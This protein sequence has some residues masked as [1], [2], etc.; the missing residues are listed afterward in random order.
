M[1]PKSIGIIGGLGGM[2]RAM[3]RF[4]TEA[5]YPVEV[6]DTVDGPISWESIAENDV[7]L[8]AVPIPA[9]EGVVRDL[10]PFTRENGL[11]MDIASIKDAPVQSM[12]QHCR[13][14]VIGTHP[15]FGPSTASLEK[16]VVFLCPG[17]SKQWIDWLMVFLADQGTRVVEIEPDKHDRLMGTVQVLRHMLLLCLGR[18]LMSLDFDLANDLPSS[19]PWFSHLVEMLRHQMDQSPELYADIASHNPATPEVADHFLHA[20]EEI[21]ASYLS[22]NHSNMIRI[23]NEVSSYMSAA[24]SR[25]HGQPCN[26]ES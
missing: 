16:Q 3:G 24:S 22:K 6:A 23:M 15:L 11:V 20:V 1:K 9:V 4:F 2:G 13:G 21:T 5:G 26:F 19:G 14:E 25:T 12:L 8:L 7:I 18:S 17:R 10:G